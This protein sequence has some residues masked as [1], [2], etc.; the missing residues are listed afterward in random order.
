MIVK[1]C[2]QQKTIFPSAAHILKQRVPR[3]VQSVYILFYLLRVR[4]VRLLISITSLIRLL[5]RSCSVD[6]IVDLFPSVI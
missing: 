2:G 4:F 6:M 3:V 5:N 1:E